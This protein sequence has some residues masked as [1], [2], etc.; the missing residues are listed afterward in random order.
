MGTE[1]LEVSLISPEDK[2]C[3][4]TLADLARD[5]EGYSKFVVD[6]NLWGKEVIRRVLQTKQGRRD[7]KN[8]L[9]AELRTS[10]VSSHDTQ[11]KFLELGDAIVALRAE[12]RIRARE[13]DRAAQNSAEGTEEQHQEGSCSRRASPHKKKSKRWDW[14]G[15]ERTH[16]E[17]IADVSKATA[18]VVRYG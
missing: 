12:N 14:R 2:I 15:D 1:E 5:E 7:V 13:R 16:N 3:I 4:P 11:K 6:E 8:K 10:Q 17:M 9:T 18:H